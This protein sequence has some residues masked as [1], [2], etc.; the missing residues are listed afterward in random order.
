[1][2]K[3]ELNGRRILI[4]LAITFIITYGIEIFMIAPLIGSTDVNAAMAA[5]SMIAGVMFA[6]TFGVILTRVF[7]KEGFM[8][9][10]LYFTFK[11]K[12][13]LK[14]YG[15]VWPGFVALILI[16]TVLYFLIF[17]KQYDGNL[18]YAAA[19]LNAQLD[20]PLTTEEVRQTMLMQIVVAAVLSPFMNIVNCFGE[21]WGWRGYLLPKLLKQ[22]KVVPAILIDG[23]I[24][25]LWHAP[26]VAVAGLNYGTGYLGYPVTGI[27]AMCVFC[28][29]IGIILSYVTIKTH[30]CI[31][32][33][34]G[35][36]MING[37]ATVGIY[38]TSLENPYNVFLGP[39]PTG[40]IGAAG[41]IV[42][43]GYLLFKLHQEEK[44]SLQFEKQGD[45][46]QKES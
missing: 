12:G 40:L 11:L 22:F 26:L 25:G 41:F 15:I 1:M 3:D 28:V 19:V 32:A 27:L 36:G 8:G 29:V 16:G 45:T 38:F 37:F 30:S 7:T 44:I 6:P 43:A 31:A 35:H 23:V 18:G 13:F 46:I 20:T 14:Y 4:F 10:S 2:E 24:W 33:I 9:K 34:L 17:P 5:Q 39:A 21:E 42:L